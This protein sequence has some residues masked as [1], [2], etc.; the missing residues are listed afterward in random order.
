MRVNL[1]KTANLHFVY[2]LIH[3]SPI[4]Y[5]NNVKF[6]KRKYQLKKINGK[7]TTKLSK[8]TRDGK[9]II[10]SNLKKNMKKTKV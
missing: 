10:N 4:K 5:N 1:F 7:N 9:V 6:K 8:L 2:F 3:I